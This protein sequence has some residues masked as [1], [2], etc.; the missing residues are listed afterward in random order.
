[1]FFNSGT[2]QLPLMI[3]VRGKPEDIRTKRKDVKTVS[4]IEII[5]FS[6]YNATFISITTILFLSDCPTEVGAFGFGTN[7]DLCPTFQHK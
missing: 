7:V 4:A 2:I 1:M 6:Q 5:P 3:V